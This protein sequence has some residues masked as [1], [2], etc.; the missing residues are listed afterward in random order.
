MAIDE[1]FELGK[2][3]LLQEDCHYITRGHEAVED[4]MAVRCGCTVSKLPGEVCENA[5]EMETDQLQNAM[6]S[7][8]AMA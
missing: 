1:Q 3:G 7:W 2:D 8:L 4:M 5:V 6:L